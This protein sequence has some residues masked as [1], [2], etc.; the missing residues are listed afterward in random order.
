MFNDIN[1]NDINKFYLLLGKHVYLDE[2]IYKQEKFNEKAL[3][4]KEGSF[5]ATEKNKISQMQI[6]CMQK[7]FVRTLK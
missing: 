1:N 2:N 3:P 4:E 7:G 5:I 6:T